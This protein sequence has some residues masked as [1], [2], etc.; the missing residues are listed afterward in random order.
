MDKIMS[1]RIWLHHGLPTPDFAVLDASTELRRIAD[2]LGLP[3][4][5]KPPHE[6]STVGVTK[7][8]GPA[9]IPHAYAQAARFD[10]DV[11]AERF[12]AGRELTV[13]ILGSGRA[14]QALPVVEIVAPNGNY[15]YEHKYF[16]DDTRY[17]CPADLPPIVSDQVRQLALAAYHALGCTGWGRVDLMLDE[18]NQP[19]LLEVNATPG[20]TSHSLVPMAAKAAGMSYAE[21]CVAILAEASCK[22]R[23]P[24]YNA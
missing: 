10:T 12:I 16:S 18:L 5:I 2:Q 20:M 17:Y 15:D 14:A 23:S 9:D 24:A 13:A 19:W 8:C 1:K 4:I 11:L 3:L 7:V 22:V 21:L 6:G